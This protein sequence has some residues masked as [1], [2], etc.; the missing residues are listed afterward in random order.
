MPERPLQQGGKPWSKAPGS[1]SFKTFHF[2]SR[3]VTGCIGLLQHAAFWRLH[4]SWLFA[5]NGSFT[6]TEK[7]SALATPQHIRGAFKPWPNPRRPT[8]RKREIVLM[9]TG[10]SG[11]TSA[12]AV[13]LQP[14]CTIRQIGTSIAE[15]VCSDQCIVLHVTLHAWKG[16]RSIEDPL[17]SNLIEYVI[18]WE[19]SRTFKHNMSI[20]VPSDM[21][22]PHLPN[23]SQDPEDSTLSQGS[24]RRATTTSFRKIDHL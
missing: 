1:S 14:S 15:A 18:S 2:L 7:F 23:L 16:R 24:A 6:L 22:L 12:H 20:I 3:K 4:F 13:N 19:P 21:W 11:N 5:S 10:H 8:Q 9:A 17:I